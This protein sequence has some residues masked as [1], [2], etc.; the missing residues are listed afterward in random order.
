MAL[1]TNRSDVALRRTTA[2]DVYNGYLIPAGSYVMA[3]I[4]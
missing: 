1:A 3:N 4:W 2:D